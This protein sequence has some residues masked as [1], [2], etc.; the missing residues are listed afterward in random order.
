[1]KKQNPEI[2]PKKQPLKTTKKTSKK[3]PKK[4][5]TKKPSVKRLPSEYGKK[6]EPF[7]AE[8]K[9]YIRCGVTEEQLCEFYQV[10]KTSWAKYKKDN[11]EFAETVC[12]ARAELKTDLINQAY[13]V[14]MGFEYTE[15]KT[16]TEKDKE[17]NILKT[18]EMVHERYARPDAGMIEF[19]LINRFPSEFAR[20]PQ[21]IALRKKALELA[22]KG[23]I[24]PE[25]LEGI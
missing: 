23:V 6:V 21:A 15:T 10:G 13:K 19:L 2:T 7:L 9:K 14:A 16:T 5:T 17:G 20:D 11:P 22:E 24:P 8:I 12:N 25:Q 1:M 18:T 4:P 3:M